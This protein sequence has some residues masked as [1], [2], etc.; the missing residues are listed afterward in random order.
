M[1]RFE[2]FNFDLSEIKTWN[3]NTFRHKTSWNQTELKNA[4]WK[5]LLPNYKWCLLVSLVLG[6]ITQWLYYLYNPGLLLS[7]G[8]VRWIARVPKMSLAA[9]VIIILGIFLFGPL[10]VGCRQFY[11][12]NAEGKKPTAHGLLFIFQSGYYKNVMIIMLIRN[13]LIYLGTLLLIA[14]GFYLYYR[15]LLVPYLLA[16]QPGMKLKD[17]MDISSRMMEGQKWDA[18]LLDLSFWPFLIM[19]M[20]TWGIAG[21][22]IGWPYRHAAGTELYRELVLERY[23][24]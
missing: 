17:A 15:Y 3:R 12:E 9:V 1:A 19:S 16:E 8:I 21:A 23:F 5:C 7:M 24:H 22:L 2:M 6:L 20:L 11:M 18:F 14:P 13:A 10:E 4:A